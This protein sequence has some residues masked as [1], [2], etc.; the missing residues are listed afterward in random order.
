MY[1]RCGLCKETKSILEFH[2]DKKGG[3]GVAS[4]C[5]LCANSESRKCH[6]RRMKEVPAYVEAKRDSH[7]LTRYGITAAD[8]DKLCEQASIDG[9]AI[10][11]TLQNKSGR[12]KDK[13][14]LD[15]CHSTNKVRGMLCGN[16]N[17]GLGQF[18]DNQEIMMK[19][20]DYLQKHSASSKAGTRP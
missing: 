2:K 7:F 1:K 6:A 10:C 3:F 16:C 20:I 14:H 4:R 19:A 12:W 13:W 11:G 8:Y 17:R 15:H 18:Q 9:C 5:K